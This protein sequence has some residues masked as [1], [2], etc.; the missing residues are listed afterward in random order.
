MTGSYLFVP[1]VSISFF[2]Y[3]L[4]VL[5]VNLG[6][7]SKVLHQ[8]V[9]NTLLAAT[10]I[11][12]AILGLVLV[13][14]INYKLN[15]PYIK[16]ILKWHVDFGIAMA[17]IGIIHFIR[18]WRYYE[19]IFTVIHTYTDHK[20]KE[21]NETKY[22]FSNSK[23]VFIAALIGFNAIIFQ[24]IVLR[25]MMNI[26]SGNE[27]IAGFVLATWM[28][29]T[30]IGAMVSTKLKKSNALIGLIPKIIVWLGILPLGV[31]GLLYFSKWMFFPPGV[32]IDIRYT[33][34]IML[35]LLAP[36]CVISGYS[37]SLLV[38]LFRKQFHS[39]RTDSLYAFE[40]LG[41][42]AGGILVSFV[43]LFW[44]TSMR[45]LAV[46]LGIQLISAYFI[47][48]P[49]DS[50]FRIKYFLGLLV[51][52]TLFVLPVDNW[53]KSLVFT[54]QKIIKNTET[55]YGNVVLT[56][57][58]SQV[59]FFTSHNL[60]F[61]SENII[62]NEECI[63]YAMLQH[64]SPHNIL[65]VS[66]GNICL[67]KEIIKYPEIKHIDYI[68][69]NRWLL[70]NATL[71]DSVMY[72]SRIRVV[73]TNIRRYIASSPDVFDVIIIAANYPVS[74]QQN[75]FYTVEFF[76]ELNARCNA[77]TI[78]SLSLP[79]LG[80]YVS[81]ENIAQHSLI[82]NT[83]KAVFPNVIIIP[84]E[85]D[86][87]LASQSQLSIAISK[88][89]KLHGIGNTYINPYYIDDFS[90]AERS[91]QF[92]GPMRDTALLN[93]DFQPRAVF[94]SN[95]VFLSK[96]SVHWLYL[97]I[98]VLLLILPFFWMDRFDLSIY[99]AGFSISSFEVLLIMAFQIMF[100][101]V[102][103]ASGIIIAVCM[104][105]LAFGAIIGAQRINITTKNQI[106]SLQ[107][108]FGLLIVL[109]TMA[110]VSIPENLPQVILYIILFLSAVIPSIIAGI[111]FSNIVK[112]KL[113]TGYAASGKIYAVDL[114]GSALGAFAVSAFLLPFIGFM[115]SGIV[116][117]GLNGLVSLF[118]L[119]PKKY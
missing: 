30:G 74:L 80:N 117:F 78:V 75:R 72:D 102:Y 37:F 16:Q 70:N 2:L 21:D 79:P 65:L 97:L 43:F 39:F 35:V 61:S 107:A 87:F 17:V 89:A 92:F 105:G 25:E 28:T 4:S 3:F 90:I 93:H 81:K 18:H 15:I 34:C 115:Y 22:S 64:K 86:Y 54:N 106:A 103:A 94:N 104:A 51:S 111:Q 69:E 73:N 10:F 68:E 76:K 49:Q 114:I 31:I 36:Y 45:T 99:I 96:F 71:F 55:P 112:Y 41:S 91:K 42:V 95:N 24:A 46:M 50:A 38:H 60:L 29:L 23:I 48:G 66:G 44:F 88:L 57:Q 84:G 101:F 26:M 27:L 83:L 33:I 14:Q 116:I 53:L 47:S 108:V 56:K 77:S 58:G 8:K 98:P 100:G 9:W 119:I 32:L 118:L 82:F 113:S 11:V 19:E 7:L 67:I 13:L 63:H 85:K 40:T 52:V 110:I 12:A 5:F 1:I 20:T 6:I 109:L 62:E 59:N